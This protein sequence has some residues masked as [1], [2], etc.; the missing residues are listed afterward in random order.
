MSVLA[1][2]DRKATLFDPSLLRGKKL[3]TRSD[4]VYVL[5]DVLRDMVTKFASAI[6]YSKASPNRIEIHVPITGCSY[7]THG[8]VFI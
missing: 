5:L 3:Y 6:S 7:M 8:R 4:V 2:G 1:W